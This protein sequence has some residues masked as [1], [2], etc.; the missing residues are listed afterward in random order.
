MREDARIT[1]TTIQLSRD[2][3]SLTLTTVLDLAPVTE[4]HGDLQIGIC[5]VIEANDGVIGY[6][7]LTHPASR[8]DFHHRDG[9]TLRMDPA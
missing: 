8:P 3:D 5:C 1:R 2:L 4:T 6:W 9:F 7:A